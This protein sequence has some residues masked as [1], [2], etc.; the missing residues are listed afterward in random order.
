MSILIGIFINCCM[1]CVWTLLETM[2]LGEVQPNNIDTIVWFM[3][4]PFVIDA[5]RSW[6]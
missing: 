1:A 2:F 4:L 6:C 5:V 3:Y